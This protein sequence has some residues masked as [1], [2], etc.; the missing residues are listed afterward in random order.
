MSGDREVVYSPEYYRQY[1]NGD[2]EAVGG[3]T[4]ETDLE[5][6]IKKVKATLEHH[7]EQG[8][9]IVKEVQTDKGIFPPD[10][11]GNPVVVRDFEPDE[12]VDRK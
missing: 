8:A 9:E 10:G 11:A 3:G 4:I 7:P 1:E 5:T 2:R 6:Q 12:I